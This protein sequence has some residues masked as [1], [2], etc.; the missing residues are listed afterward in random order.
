MPFQSEAQRRFMWANHPQIAQRWANEYGS[1]PQLKGLPPGNPKDVQDRRVK[2]KNSLPRGM[3][4]RKG[5]GPGGADNSHRDD[6]W[7]DKRIRD[8]ALKRLTRG[9]N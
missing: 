3:G 4:T 5:K 6:I 8:A 2:P 9:K 7:M 1:K